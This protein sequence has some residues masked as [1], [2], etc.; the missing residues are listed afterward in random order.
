MK[1]LKSSLEDL[2]EIFEKGITAH[3]ITETLCSFDESAIAQ[4][5]KKLLVEKN[6]DVVGVRTYS[7]INGYACKKDLAEGKLGEYFKNFDPSEILPDT[8][9]ISEV[10]KVIIGS[11]HV[12]ISSFGGVVGIITRGDL[13]KIPIRMWL[14]SL[15]SLI[16][17]QMLRIIRERF[18]ENSW[19]KKIHPKRKIKAEN[20]FNDRKNKKEEIDLLDC[21]QFC[22]KYTIISRTE[23]L[24]EK[25]QYAKKKKEFRKLLKRLEGLRND[26]AHAQDIIT[27]DWPNIIDLSTTA[28]EFLKNCETINVTEDGYSSSI[29]R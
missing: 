5:V 19:D 6:Y 2:R 10:L 22:D 23:D 1:Q 15:I 12:F 24:L 26:L 29:I 18:P 8:I 17:M 7:K 20:C 14:F 9:S 25:L 27:T 13:Q 3:H 21:L 4:E 11:N 16:E 28:E